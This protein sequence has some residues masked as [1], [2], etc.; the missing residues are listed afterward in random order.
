[1]CV[2]LIVLLCVALHVL[3]LTLYKTLALPPNILFVVRVHITNRIRVRSTRI[4]Y[5]TILEIFIG[6]ICRCG[7]GRIRHTMCSRRRN[8]TSQAFP[9]SELYAV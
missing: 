6:S 7:R 4:V 5:L 8:R 9:Y 1:M 3:L 2:L